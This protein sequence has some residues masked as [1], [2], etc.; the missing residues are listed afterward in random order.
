MVNIN[1]ILVV[2]VCFVLLIAIIIGGK[3]LISVKNYQKAV[4]D[5]K[6]GTIELSKVSDGEY[7]GT[8]NVDYIYAKVIVTVKDHE[9]KNINLLE[10]KNEKGKPAEVITDKVVKEQSV[11]VDTVSGATNSS[12]VILKAI[13]SALVSGTQK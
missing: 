1:K 9:I 13:E 10:H 3:Y 11:Q 7:T 12:K 5:L 2:A 6:I 8:C 4:K